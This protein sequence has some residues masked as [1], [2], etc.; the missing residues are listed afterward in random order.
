MCVCVCV[1]VC[2]C[3]SIDIRVDSHIDGASTCVYTRARETACVGV[4]MF[5]FYYGLYELLQTLLV[6]PPIDNPAVGGQQ[7]HLASSA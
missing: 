3:A 4:H 1:C 2:V 5:V 7:G 6:H